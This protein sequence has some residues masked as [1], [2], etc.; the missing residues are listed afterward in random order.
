MAG[1]EELEIHSKSYLVR[2]VK[3]Q[4]GHT[5]SWSLQPHKKS[6]NFGIFKHLGQ[7]APSASSALN[8]DSNSAESS[9]DNA[10][11]SAVIEKLRSAGLKPTQWVGKCEADKISQGI[12]DVPLHDGGNY[13][14]VFDNTFSK[15]TGK[16]ATF[17]LMTYPT[18]TPPQSVHQVHPPHALA[19]VSN[20]GGSGK[21]ASPK[22]GPTNNSSTSIDNPRTARGG[23][24][25]SGAKSI[26]RL[27]SASSANS[28]ATQVHTGILQKRRRKRHQ[29]WARRFFSLDYTSSTLSYY[30]DRN[31]SALRG[32]IPLNLAAVAANDATREISID[33]GA[34]IWHLRANNEQDF[35]AWRTALERAS[36][37]SKD[38]RVVTPASPLLQIPSNTVSRHLPDPNEDIEWEQIES[39]V[40]KVSGSRDAVRRL[41]KDTDPKYLTSSS[42]STAATAAAAAG[43]RRSQSLQASAAESSSVNGDEYP[44]FQPKRPFWKRKP[45]STNTNKRQNGAVH[46]AAPSPS[47][48]ALTEEPKP[49]SVTS[50]TD[51][52]DEIHENLMAILRDLDC[53]VGE[54][55]NL[56]GESKQRRHP[57][58][59]TISSRV[60]MES[61]ASQ[62]FFDAE[63]GPTSPLLTIQH[64]SEV[65]AEDEDVDVDDDALSSCSE[66]DS[67]QKES[68]AV[69]FPPKPKSMSP[70]PLDSVQRRKTVAAPI[71]PPPSLIGFLRKNVG[72]DLSAVT[73]P[74]TANEP[75]SL[76]QRAAEC[77]EYSPLLD[78]AAS[79]TDGL[80]RL[81]YVTAFALSSLSS[82]RVKER[83]IRKPFNPLLGET[84]ELVR[85]DRGFRLL[86][87]KVSHRPVQ[88]AYQADSRDWSLTQSPKPSQKF[89]G[90]SAEITTDGKTR[91]SLHSTG[92]HFSWGNA[93]SFLRNIIA[94]EKY[95]EPVGE[96]VVVNE[97]TGQK[98]VSTFKAGGMFSGRSEEVIVKAFDVHGHELPLGLT[99]TWTGSLQLTEHGSPT[100]KTIWASG[101]LVDQAA[102]RYG[103]PTFAATLN[104]TTPIE[105]GKLPPTDSRLRP[106]Q[107]A[108][109]NNELD[110]AEE[111]KAQLEEKQRE[112]RRELED[113]GGVYKPRWFTQVVT[114]GA[115]NSSSDGGEIVWKM[116]SG[117]DGYWEER[118]RGEWSNVVPIFKL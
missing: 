64:D 20:I 26:K 49:R 18:A 98:T 79:A 85:E 90:K 4:G 38:D 33:S 52:D 42:A 29:G 99:G 53:V 116:K 7:P 107:R 57:P 96:M 114:S 21:R 109:E 41:A 16:M 69:L 87:E 3:V 13:A 104:E 2:W 39:L 88:L 76:L 63:A 82:S 74:V 117:K 8:A 65:E 56:I 32:A 92:D 12:F 113:S 72:K 106:D 73:M 34:E 31:S 86:V 15:T 46:L 84:F 54:F 60:S 45:S 9:A 95:V 28:A 66:G 101:S 70:L 6:L 11:A 44:D 62:E 115:L 24:S 30:H 61:D 91:L 27:N 67:L 58:I 35:A 40:S 83:A 51:R 48:E 102:K 108:L 75:L 14:L 36:K 22:L 111:L 10:Q 105:K 110:A 19:T 17:V 47:N 100:N 5:I 118:S 78:K 81:V 55:T 77:M 94:G 97:T 103:F 71:M 1:M 25:V 50:H 37:Q 80:E 59:T 93:T 89:W 68:S 23:R 43:R 112:R